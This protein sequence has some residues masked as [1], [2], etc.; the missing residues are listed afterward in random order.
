VPPA[1]ERTRSRV[2]SCRCAARYGG[3]AAWDTAVREI[4]V[5][6]E[7]RRVE[8]VFRDRGQAK[9]AVAAALR[10]A[11]DVQTPHALVE[12]E[13]GVHVILH[14]T[15]HVAQAVRLLLEYGAYS[16]AER[17]PGPG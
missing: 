5:V 17:E 11:L 6:V 9:Q 2:G 4:G 14:T 8:G 1:P 3:W 16:A 7:S 13:S 12:D 15:R 10:Q